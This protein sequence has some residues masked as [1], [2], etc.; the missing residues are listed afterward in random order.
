MRH[1]HKLPA[2]FSHHTITSWSLDPVRAK[3]INDNTLRGRWLESRQTGKKRKGH[4]I[5]VRPERHLQIITKLLRYVVKIL[6]LKRQRKQGE[7][8]IF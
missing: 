4:S 7:C 8:N 1:C 3:F 6:S 5:K 2:Y